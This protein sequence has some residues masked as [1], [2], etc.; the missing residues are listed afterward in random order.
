[1]NLEFEAQS[2][3][4]LL[5][6]STWVHHQAFVLPQGRTSWINPASLQGSGAN[7]N[8]DGGDD[9]GDN[10]GDNDGADKEDNEDGASGDSAQQEPETGPVLLTSIEQDE[11]LEQGVPAWSIRLASS[12]LPS[13]FAPVFARS[14]RWPGAVAVTYQKKFANVYVG[15]G[16][17]YEPKWHLPA[18]AQPKLEYGIKAEK[19]EANPDEP[20]STG[21]INYQFPQDVV[22]LADPTLEEEKA[23]EE[24]KKA[25]EEEKEE[26]NSAE[27]EEDAD[28]EDN[29]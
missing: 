7:K 14:N 23:F 12:R 18:L 28:A 10:D 25:K 8:G 11:E 13:K 29:E 3:E 21:E 26:A 16:I 5:Q 2:P 22:E 4:E 24:S 9:E 17:K 27:K 15:D 6:P 20:A 1:M 19:K